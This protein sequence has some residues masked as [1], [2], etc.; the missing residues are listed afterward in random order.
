MDIMVTA[1]ILDTSD[2]FFEEVVASSV[3][4]PDFV[5]RQWLNDQIVAALDKPNS[6]YLLLT[7]EPGAGKT[8]VAASLA[9]QHSDWLRY[10]IRRNSWAVLSGGDIR[11]FLLS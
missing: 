5:S 8:V 11:S 9:R 10:F 3:D 4:D 6:R 7:G 2:L 1:G